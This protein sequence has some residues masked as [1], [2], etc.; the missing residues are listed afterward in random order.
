MTAHFRI[1][2]GRPKKTDDEIQ[3]V[4]DK[5]LVATRTVFGTYGTRG[6]TVQ[7]IIQCADISRPT[8]YKYFANSDEP[9]DFIIEQANLKL[10]KKMMKVS[11][12]HSITVSRILAVIDTYI[13]WG[14]GEIEILASIHQELLI[15]GSPVSKHRAD[16]LGSIYTIL[17]RT[18]RE[19]GREVPDKVVFES[20]IM[21]AENI[22]YHLLLQS[23]PSKTDKYR[24]DMLKL[25]IALFGGV[26]DWKDAICDSFLFDKNNI[27]SQ[28]APVDQGQ[29]A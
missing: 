6:T 19:E 24:A 3:G 9:L 4:K 26:D 25:A 13:E 11:D 10:V 20:V 1:K 2:R 8:F 28:T 21:G 29:R 15:K 5:I 16:T 14:R 27:S 18:L 23:N 22:G 12:D 17:E 7:K